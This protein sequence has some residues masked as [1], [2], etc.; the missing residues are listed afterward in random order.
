MIAETP[1]LAIST[2]EIEHN[3]TAL[4]DEFLVHRMGLIPLR[5]T[6]TESDVGAVFGLVS[7]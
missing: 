4:H 1:C 5:F 2:V 7:G 3:T 6:D